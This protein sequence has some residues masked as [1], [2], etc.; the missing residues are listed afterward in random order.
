MKICLIRP[1]IVV[2]A[3]NIT[4][5]FTPPLGMAYVAGALRGRLRSSLLMLWGVIRYPA[6]GRPCCSMACLRNRL[7]A[8]LTGY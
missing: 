2:P 4:T 1:S 6:S 3:R 8:R 7:L 5:I